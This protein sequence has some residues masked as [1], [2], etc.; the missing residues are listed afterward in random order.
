MILNIL[1]TNSRVFNVSTDHK[2]QI[3]IR[4]GVIILRQLSVNCT[5]DLIE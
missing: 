4:K 3:A 5:Y 1:F 2:N